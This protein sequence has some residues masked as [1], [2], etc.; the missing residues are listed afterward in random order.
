MS[1]PAKPLPVPTAGSL[2]FWDG[3][4]RHELLLPH[5]RDCRAPWF[6]PAALCPRCLGTNWDWTRS[7]GRGR[8]YSFVVYHR[9]YHPGFAK[10]VPYVVALVELDEGPRF[11]SNIVDCSPAEVRCDMPV[12]VV[13][14]AASEGVVLPKFRPIDSHA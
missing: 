13:F 4:R 12:E 10:D 6:P 9:V 7:S 8:V 14:E 11:M 3:C 5:C 2:P 1:E